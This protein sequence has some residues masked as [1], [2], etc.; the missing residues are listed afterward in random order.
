LKPSIMTTIERFTNPFTEESCDIFSLV[1]KA[2]GLM[3]EKVKSGL[4]TD[5]TI[6]DSE[7]LI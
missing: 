6:G 1:M 5:S 2:V 4:C 3:P 7:Q